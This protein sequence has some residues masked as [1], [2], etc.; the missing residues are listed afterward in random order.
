MPRD[1][2]CIVVPFRDNPEQNRSKHLDSFVKAMQKHPDWEVLVV[3]QSQDG[4]KFNRGALLNVGTRIAEESGFPYVIYHDVDLIPKAALVPQQEAFPSKPIHIGKA[5]EKQDYPNF[6]GGVLSISI[7]D[8][9]KINGFPNHFWGWGGEDDAMSARL[10]QKKITVFQPTV[11]SG[12]RELAHVDTR[13]K[14]EWKN[15]RKWEDRAADT[16]RKGQSTIDQTVQEEVDLAP[17]VK[18]VNVQ[19]PEF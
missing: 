16:P 11:Q 18:K 17:N 3:E 1:Q 12:F 7:E 10:K 6:L 13:T 5:M 8:V 4:R 15:M 14:Q 19:L 2:P 9:K